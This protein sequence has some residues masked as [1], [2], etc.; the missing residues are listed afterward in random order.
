MKRKEGKLPCRAQHVQTP[1][2]VRRVEMKVKAKEARPERE[3]NAA[4]P[5]GLS[6][7]VRREEGSCG[8]C[9]KGVRERSEKKSSKR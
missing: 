3:A 7:A 4:R 9:K 2:W 1:R 6:Q 5:R 8:S